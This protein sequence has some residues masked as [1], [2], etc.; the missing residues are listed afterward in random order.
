MGVGELTLES[1]KATIENSKNQATSAQ[2]P[3]KKGSTLRKALVVGAGIGVLS[4]TG[5]ILAARETL[6]QPIDSRN[7]VIGGRWTN[8]C[9]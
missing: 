9:F 7:L 2:L 8:Y 6:R 1:P 4:E 5:R 3:D